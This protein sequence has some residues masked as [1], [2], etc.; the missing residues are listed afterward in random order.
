VSDC[1]APATIEVGGVGLN[2]TAIGPGRVM[3]MVAEALT[4]VL[5]TEVA[6]TVA[7]F[8]VGIA[9]GAV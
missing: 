4:A 1:V 7:V 2:V 6:V 3:V 5:V 9:D 8:P